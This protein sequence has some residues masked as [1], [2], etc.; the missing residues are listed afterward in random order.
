MGI[1]GLRSRVTVGFMGIAGLLFLSGMLS[2]FELSRLSDATDEILRANRRNMELSQD[3]IHSLQGQNDAFVRIVAF[4]EHTLDSSCMESVT[5][6]EQAVEQAMIRTSQ[7]ELLDSMLYA[8]QRIRTLSQRLVDEAHVESD[9]VG[10]SRDIYNEYQPLYNSMLGLVDE[11]IN[12]SQNILAP[13]AESLRHNAYRAVTPIFI[14]LVVMIVIVLLLY[15]FMMLY[16]VNPI[17]VMNKSLTGFINYKIPFTP[18][19]ECRDEVEELRDKIEK[20]T[21]VAMKSKS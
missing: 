18:K 7:V 3:L 14:S 11:Y 1:K 13:R 5:Y 21:L 4:G 10:S 12:T 15:Y 2:F 6:L 19:A 17:V 8:V 16:C 9:T 20:L